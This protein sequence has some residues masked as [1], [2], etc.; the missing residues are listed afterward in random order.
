MKMKVTKDIYEYIINFTNP[1]TTLHMLSVN[2]YFRK[3]LL[4]ILKNKYPLLDNKNE[5][6]YIQEIHYMNLLERK[7]DIPYISSIYF[8]P[9]KFYINF[10]YIK[11]IYDY[12]LMHASESG[13]ISIVKHMIKKGAN[14]FNWGLEAAKEFHHLHII[15]F[16][17][18]E[19]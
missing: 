6:E 12:A 15:D 17:H 19:I 16:L 18:S 11:Y 1:E 14:K 2:K 5:K 4:R 9:K 10:R 3:S 7:F 13:E 8:S